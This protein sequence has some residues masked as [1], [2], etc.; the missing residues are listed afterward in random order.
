[1]IAAFRKQIQKSRIQSNLS[2]QSSDNTSTAS[3]KIKKRDLK[4]VERKLI[5]RISKLDM[6]QDN[7][8]QLGVH[9]FV[10]EILLWEFGENLREDPD[11]IQVLDEVMN[12]FVN[13]QQTKLQFI[14]LFSQMRISAKNPDL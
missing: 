13:D 9:M 12:A 7:D 14:T 1:M 3:E 6:T 10:Q 8:F 5:E 2:V 4:Q 11:F